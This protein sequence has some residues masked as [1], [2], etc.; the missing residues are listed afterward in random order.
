MGDSV[1]ISELVEEIELLRKRLRE[2]WDNKQL[3]SHPV[4]VQL[5]QR[6]DVKISQYQRLTSE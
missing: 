4:I 6:L 1:I 2:E 5:S 3:L